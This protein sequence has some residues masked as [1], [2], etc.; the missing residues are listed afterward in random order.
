MGVTAREIAEFLNAPIWG[1]PN[2]SVSMIT[3]LLPGQDGALSFCKLETI[4]SLPFIQDS[5][6][7]IV[8]CQDSLPVIVLNNKT[9]IPA[10]N[11]RLAFVKVANKFFPW[12]K[13]KPGIN[14]TAII[15]PG[16]KIDSSV[17]IGPYCVVGEGVEIGQNSVIYG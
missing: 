11:S 5:M 17:S 2:R 12:R 16:A 14:P 9:V 7:T 3:K 6:C 4:D 1:N 13:F 8:I 15:G 10:P